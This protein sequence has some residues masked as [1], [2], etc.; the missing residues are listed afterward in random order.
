MSTKNKRGQN[1]GS[2]RDRKDGTFE[3]RYTVGKDAKGKQIQKSI[4]GKTKTEV[5]EKLKAVLHELSTGSYLEPTKITFSNWLNTWFNEYISNSIKLSTKVSYDLYINKHIIPILGHVYLKDLKAETFQKFYNEK[6]LGGRLDDK[7]GLNPKTIKNMHNMIH[8]ALEQA[9][10]NNL[11]VRN[12]SKSVVLPKI[13]K[14]DMRVLNPKEQNK[15]LEVARKDR[16][17]M[18]IVL[19][20]ATGL[21]LGELLAL[22]WSDIDMKTGTLSVKR[23]INRLKSFNSGSG[24]KTSIVIGEPKTKNSKRLI[25]LQGIILRELRIHKI[26]QRKEKKVAF[27][28]YEDSDFVFASPLGRPVE[29]R[30]FQ[31][32]FYGMIEEVK[33]KAANFHC[34]RHTFATRALEAGIP[35][36]TVSEI[37]GHANISTTLD[38]YSHVSLELKKESMEK[39]SNLFII[40]PVEQQEKEDDVINNKVI[41]II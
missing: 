11:L 34:I 2:I 21:R 7:G 13:I 12:V 37:L 31:D 5:R 19:D 14:R 41:R 15:L 36:K 16:L 27:G 40:N 18:A 20:L 4:Y 28:K 23:T 3:A 6:L 10:K 26:N 22:Q 33:I 9:L 32:V 1:E 38:L 30:T 25:P 29:P 24:N 35:A 8:S 17:G 39:L